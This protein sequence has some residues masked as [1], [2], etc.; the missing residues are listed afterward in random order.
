MSL[1]AFQLAGLYAVHSIARGAELAGIAAFTAGA[2]GPLRGAWLDR[3]EMRGGLQLSCYAAALF[4]GLFTVAVAAKAPFLVLLTLA[5]LLGLSIGGIWGGFRALL[6]NSVP[7]ALLRRAHF[8]ESL[9][10]EIG[11]GLGPLAVTLIAALAG[12]VVALT[13]MTAVFICAAVMLR[14]VAPL[15]PGKRSDRRAGRLTVPIVFICAV[16]GFQSFGFGLVEGNVPSRMAELGHSADAAGVFL[17]LLSVGSVIGGLI[18]SFVPISTRRPALLGAGL[19]ALFAVLIIPSTLATSVLTFGSTL[20]FASLMLV[21]LSGLAA[22]EIEAQLGDHGRGRIFAIF[23][24]A[25]QV[26]GGLGVAVNGVLQSYIEPSE[27][28]LVSVGLFAVIALVLV[29]VGLLIGR[30]TT[31]EVSSP[32]DEISAAESTLAAATDR[33]SIGPTQ[34]ITEEK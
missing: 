6:L 19:F 26:G 14:Q 3:R 31:I 11:Y 23:I 27:V 20:L 34:R 18:V 32:F 25:V 16:G 1:L 9:S 30:N 28:P 24:G 8:V 5:I 33:A 15:A 7:P 17:A 4:M 22:A 21:P 29:V 13:V 10:T 2:A 12:V